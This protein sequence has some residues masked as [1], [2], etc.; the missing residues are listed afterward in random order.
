VLPD[1]KIE[2]R[3]LAPAAYRDLGQRSVRQLCEP[4]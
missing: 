1:D 3:D 4:C 2:Q